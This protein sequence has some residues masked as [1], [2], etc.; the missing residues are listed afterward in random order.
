MVLTS[1]PH[2]CC[3]PKKDCRISTILAGC[4]DGRLGSVGAVDTGPRRCESP[5]VLPQSPAPPSRA[6]LHCSLTVVCAGSRWSWFDAGPAQNWL[7][8]A[9]V[10]LLHEGRDLLAKGCAYCTKAPRTRSTPNPPPVAPHPRAVHPG[11]AGSHRTDR[12]SPSGRLKPQL[13]RPAGAPT[14]SPS[15]RSY[16]MPRGRGFRVLCCLMTSESFGCHDI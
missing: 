1:T 16:L 8:M 11:D 3:T 15:P 4:F 14:L 2:R 6:L 12:V 10:G 5:W 13:S 7:E 9:R